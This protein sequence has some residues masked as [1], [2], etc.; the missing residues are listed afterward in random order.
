MRHRLLPLTIALCC[1]LLI[2]GCGQRVYVTT[3]HQ[4]TGYLQ[5]LNYAFNPAD[6]NK[7]MR[8]ILGWHLQQAGMKE[9]T[10]PASDLVIEYDFYVRRN[11]ERA[12]PEFSIDKSG[13]TVMREPPPSRTR[14]TRKAILSVTLMDGPDFMKGLTSYAHKAQ[15]SRTLSGPENLEE[16]AEELSRAIFENLP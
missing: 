10:L 9:S 8:R 5:G 7:T 13:A 6:K 1:C 16:V 2:A 14:T 12:A 15:A 4:F 11:E 3:Q